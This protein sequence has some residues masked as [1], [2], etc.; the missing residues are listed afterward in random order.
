MG[1]PARKSLILKIITQ[2]SIKK[3]NEKFRDRDNIYDKSNCNKK[4]STQNAQKLISNLSGQ[5]NSIR[6]NSEIQNY[7]NITNLSII[8]RS[9]RCQTIG[10]DFQLLILIKKTVIL[11]FSNLSSNDIFS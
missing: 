5:N 4:S 6:S 3:K 2:K 8:R 10:R 1:R 9:P 7:N 11:T